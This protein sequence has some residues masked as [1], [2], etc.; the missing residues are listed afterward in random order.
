MNFSAFRNF[1]KTVAITAGVWLIFLLYPVQFLWS[2][3]SYT[4]WQTYGG[5]ASILAFSILYVIGFGANRLISIDSAPHRVLA[6]TGVLLVPAFFLYLTLGPWVLFLATYFVSLWAFTLPELGIKVGVAITLVTAFVM[7]VFYRTVWDNGG[8]GFIIGAGFVLLFAQ[9]MNNNEAKRLR[10]QELA[11]AKQAEKI[12]RDVHD[13]L[14]HSLTVI[15]LKAELAEALVESQPEKA[16]NEMRQIA[17]LSR[18]ALAEVRATVTRMKSPNFAGELEA[19]RRALETA[20]ISAHL[21]SADQVQVPGN[22]AT[23]FSWVLREAV[24]NV[25]RH[26][27]ARSCWVGVEAERIEIMD[28]GTAETIVP[29]N[30]LSGLRDRV[31][32]AGGDLILTSGDFTRLL[33]TMNGNSNPLL[34]PLSSKGDSA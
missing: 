5:T 28:D 29:G 16:S 25:V 13:I 20:R 19:S 2:E 15:N 17:E 26:S 12:A 3:P 6:W 14:G 10:E 8:Y 24:T 33:V 4:G 9:L 27:S 32:E 7:F 11:Q 23:L 34:D 22:N 30:G 21:P 18:T 31:Q 1:D